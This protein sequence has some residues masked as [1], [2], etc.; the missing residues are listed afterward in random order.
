MTYKDII[1]CTA[2]YY[3]GLTPI[4][5]AAA[6]LV[7]VDGMVWK[8]RHGIRDAEGLHDAMRRVLGDT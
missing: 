6:D 5:R 3:E 1:I 7:I 8:D 2:R 4:Q